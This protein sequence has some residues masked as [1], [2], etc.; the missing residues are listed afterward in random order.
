[1]PQQIPKWRF[2][3]VWD[4]RNLKRAIGELPKRFQT[5]GKKTLAE[6]TQRIV[7]RMSVEGKP[8]KYP[9][10]WDSDRQRRYVMAM[11]REQDELPYTRKNIY[12][13]SWKRKTVTNGYIIKAPHPAGAIG[14]LM[15]GWQSRITKGRWANLARVVFEEVSKLPKIGRASCRERV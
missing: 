1:M 15:S 14:G 13:N 11:L 6:I 8:V 12:I 9:I 10:K 3:P 2:R 5:A 4:S 7:E